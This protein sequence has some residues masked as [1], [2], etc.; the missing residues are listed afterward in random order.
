MRS[1]SLLM[2]PSRDFSVVLSIQKS[3]PHSGWNDNATKIRGRGD[4]PSRISRW[5]KRNARRINFKHMLQ[6]LRSSVNR[7]LID[8]TTIT[9]YLGIFRFD[10]SPWWLCFVF[11]TWDNVTNDV[12]TVIE[13]RSSSH[14]WLRRLELDNICAMGRSICSTSGC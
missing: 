10:F 6:M 9:P 12:F 13:S 14:L 1:V 8:L 4:V 5:Q 11:R 7:Y 3:Q 2:T